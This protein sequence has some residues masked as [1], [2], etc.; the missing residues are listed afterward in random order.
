M[1]QKN[2]K[3]TMVNTIKKWFR[4]SDFW[5]SF[6]ENLAEEMNK[7]ESDAEEAKNFGAMEEL[8]LNSFSLMS[9]SVDYSEVCRWLP[10]NSHSDIDKV[11]IE[12]IK[13]NILSVIGGRFSPT[14]VVEASM[15][16]TRDMLDRLR[17]K[18][19]EPEEEYYD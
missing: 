5:P 11:L 7:I 1:K 14:S 12:M 2:T 19:F 17:Y 9:R 10:N 15:L 18:P 3:N 16:S 13:K 6:Y 8:L 4:K